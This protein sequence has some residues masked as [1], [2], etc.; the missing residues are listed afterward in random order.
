MKS[1]SR[2]RQTKL[3][4]LEQAV[5]DGLLPEAYAAVREASRR[6]N[7]QRH[8]DVQLMAGMV[9]HDGKIA[10]MGTGEGK[11]LVAT[12]SLYLNALTGRG[13]HLVTPND[14]LSRVGA[15]WMGPVY[16]R[17]G[18]RTAVIAHEFAGVYEPNFSDPSPHGDDRL[19]HFMPVARREAYQADILYATNNELGFDYLRDNMVLDVSQMVQRELNFAI[20]DEVDNI[21]ID[22]ART[23]LIISGPAEE[24][25][26]EYRRFSQ[27]MPRL[28]EGDDYAIDLKLRVVSPTEEGIIK[29]SACWGFLRTSPCMTP[30]T[31]N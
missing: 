4:D 28:Q 20:V 17:L 6:A 13:V 9:L 5:M 24:S 2:K 12:L 8:F 22:E 18:M 7:G 11:T 25:S 21:L 14:Y 10:E 19:N 27:L 16:L 31:W 26:S 30:N 29:L 15:G 3:I 23:P 1:N